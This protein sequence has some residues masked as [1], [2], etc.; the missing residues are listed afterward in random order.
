MKEIILSDEENYVTEYR[1]KSVLLHRVQGDLRK[2]YIEVTSRCNLDCITCIRHEWQHDPG[3]MTLDLF[4]KIIGDLEK[5]KRMKEIVFGGFGEPFLH[6]QIIEMLAKAKR[7]NYRVTVTTNGQ[8]LSSEIIDKII[9]LKVDDLVISVD[10]FEKIEFENIRQGGE[11]E[12][13]LENLEELKRKKEKENTIFPR[14]NMEFVL[15]RKNKNQLEKLSSYSRGLGILSILVT[16]LLPYNEEMT[17]EILYKKGEN[18]LDMP[19]QFW[20]TPIRGLST[21]CTI[22]LPRMSWGAD[23]QCDFVGNDACA[24]TAGGDVTPCYSLMHSHRYFIFGRE[25][26]VS[27]HSFGNV[28]DNSLFEIW[29]SP[30]YLKFRNRVRNFDFPSCE[31]CKIKD[32]C[33]YT[34]QNE[35]CWGN[36]PSCADC[37]W[38]QGI[39][40]CP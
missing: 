35:D 29:N 10:S 21:M 39:V 5:M 17:D 36:Q 31:D 6:S 33:T 18:E 19:I 15:M 26:H 14:I 7:K 27:A 3:D 20:A 2:I 4:H 22:D 30:A 16:N 25:K 1:D 12:L 37:L 13:L 11:L 28:G 34:E 8:S 32:K 23:R 24:V 40:R 9:E 38:A